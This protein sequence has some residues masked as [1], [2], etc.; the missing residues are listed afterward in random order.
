MK[1]FD[2]VLNPREIRRRLGLNQEQFWTQ[3]G[4]TQSGGSR[5]DKVAEALGAHG[6]HADSPAT[7]ESALAKAVD[8]RRP[9]CINV[10]IQRV[11]AP[12]IVRS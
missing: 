6:L 7:L 11:A 1:L 2:R 8:S 10:P 12:R 5:Y 9:T 4:V 3:I